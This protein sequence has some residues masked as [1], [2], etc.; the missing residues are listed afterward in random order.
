MFKINKLKKYNIA[1]VPKTKS[2]QI[3]ELASNYSNIKHNYCIEENSLPHVTVCQFYLDSEDLSDVWKSVCSKLDLTSIKLTFN[4]ISHITF[5]SNTYW[6]SLM[7]NERELLFSIYGTVSSLVSSIRKDEYDPHMTLFNYKKE[8]KDENIDQ[9]LRSIVIEDNFDLVVGESDQNGQL[10][11]IVATF[12]NVEQL[13]F[14][15]K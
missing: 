5:G 6:V 14:N 10:V 13:R 2:N 8:C 9:E 12:C 11:S 7:P 3:N 15:Q 4:S 1:F